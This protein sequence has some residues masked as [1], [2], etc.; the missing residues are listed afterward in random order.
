MIM[1]DKENRLNFDLT[2]STLQSFKKVS[3]ID[4]TH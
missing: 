2:A 3:S 4:F 1:K